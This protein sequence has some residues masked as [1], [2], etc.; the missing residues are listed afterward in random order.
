VPDRSILVLGNETEGLRTDLQHLCQHRVT[1]PIK[2]EV[3]SLNVSSA[4]GIMLYEWNRQ[5]H[6][7]R[8]NGAPSY[9]KG[10]TFTE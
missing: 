7:P 3:D 8:S 2:S 4:A 9:L 10:E 1:I 6:P 5:R